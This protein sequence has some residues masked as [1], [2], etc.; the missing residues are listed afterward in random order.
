MLVCMKM[1]SNDKITNRLGDK[2]YASFNVKA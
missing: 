2:L 1:L